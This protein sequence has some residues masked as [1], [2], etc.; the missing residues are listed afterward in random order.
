[1]ADHQDVA[2]LR[3]AIAEMAF[4]LPVHLA[5]QG[6]GGVVI[7]QVAPLRLH[8][9]GFRHAMGREHHVGVGRHL[10]QLLHEHR[11]LR[12]QRLHHRA[13]V[14]DFMP[15]VDRGAEPADRFLHDPDGTVHTGAEAARTGKQNA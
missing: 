14:D 9:H 2:L 3:P 7:M 5:D 10:V 11:A 8:R 4:R 1:M 15:H 6:A 12:L 13:V